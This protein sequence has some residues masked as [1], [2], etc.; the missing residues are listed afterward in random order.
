MVSNVPGLAWDDY[1]IYFWGSGPRKFN[2]LSKD[3]QLTKK[4]DWILIKD[5]ISNK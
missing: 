4:K 1:E 2:I 5:L 3:Q